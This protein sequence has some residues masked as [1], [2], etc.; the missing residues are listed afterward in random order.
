MATTA[1]Q[2]VKP[3][4]LRDMSTG[5]IQVWWTW[6]IGVIGIWLFYETFQR[7]WNFPWLPLAT[8]LFVIG[9]GILQ[10]MRHRNSVIQHYEYM[11]KYGLKREATM[12]KCNLCGAI[13]HQP[14]GADL[15]PECY[16]S[17][18]IEIDV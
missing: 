18:I 5:A 6:V 13:F 8:A 3:S 12:F 17:G 11:I 10:T 9:Y 15:C 16:E 14:E 4:N 2:L 7:E 1:D